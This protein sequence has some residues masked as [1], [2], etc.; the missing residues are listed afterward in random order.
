MVLFVAV[1]TGL[2][3]IYITVI[4]LVPQEAYYWYYSLN[5][6]LS[7]FDH[8]PMVAYSIWIGTHLFGDTI[9]GIKFMAVVWSALTNIFLYLTMQNALKNFESKK[10]NK[11]AFTT[12]VFYNLTIFAHL[13]A[14]TMVPDTPLIFFWLLVIFFVQR[15]I[16]NRVPAYLYLAGMSLGFG[17]LS[18]YTAIAILPAIFLIFLLNPSLRRLL[19][20]PYP[21]LML[22]FVLIVFAPVLVWNLNHDWVSLKF[23]FAD[24]STE[25]KPFQTKYV[26]Q[27]IA[28]QLFMLTPL[29]L[30]MFFKTT[31][32]VIVNWKQN[33]PERYFFITAIFI[34]GGFA[35]LSLK[36]LIK[37]N[38]LLP[39]FM[40]LIL[41]A[42]ILYY[43]DDLLKS[44]WIKS[45]IMVSVFLVMIA[46]S[47]L[48][49]PNIP[50]GDGNTWSGWKE[51]AAQIAEIQE[52]KGGH[53]NVFIF[54]N[55]Y[56]TA[57]LLKFYF[58]DD[59][60]VYAQNIY[61]QPALQFNIW[62]LPASL[63]GKDALFVF[64]D[65]REYHPDLEKIGNYFDEIIPVIKNDFMFNATLKAR[66][67][68]CYYAK[69][70]KGI[71]S[72]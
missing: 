72:E 24:R 38:W 19:I 52:Q 2:R 11:I 25:L 36:T 28:S 22:I 50:L 49:I 55:S 43:R 65:R 14:I 6:D 4:P 3:L 47:I 12:V 7:Y 26:F 23:Q 67:I 61:D 40:G 15:F 53:E 68:Y 18:K 46:Y 56:K 17:L 30:I 60:N 33:T 21:Y 51:T 64:T 63:K 48:L 5:P 29:P 39:G 31:K 44:R 32:N 66:T 62:G 59:Q 57:S 70:Y 45:G 1:L 20:K 16:E 37:M 69:N 71:G 10:R 13:Y 58:S 9:F 41:T 54:A 35:A 42:V 34:V 27:L 8:P